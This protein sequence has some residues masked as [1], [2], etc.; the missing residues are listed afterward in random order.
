MK[1]KTNERPVTLAVYTAVSYTHLDVY[2]RQSFVFSTLYRKTETNDIIMIIFVT[3]I[4]IF[5]SI[6]YSIVDNI[7]SHLFAYK[8]FIN[9][10]IKIKA[11]FPSQKI[12][13]CHYCN[14]T[15]FAK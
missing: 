9:F 11:I 15:K 12:L 1:G 3:Y 5:L 4:L 7:T 10:Y 2:K 13:N 8:F 6:F 14:R